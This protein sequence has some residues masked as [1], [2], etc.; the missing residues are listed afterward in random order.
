MFCG[1]SDKLFAKCVA[2]GLGIAFGDITVSKFNDGETKIVVN[3]TV[4]GKHVFVLQSTCPPNVNDNLMELLLMISTFKRAS[5]AAITAVIPYFGYARQDRKMQSRVPISAACVAQLLESMGVDRVITV[6]LHCAQIQGFFRVPTDNLEAASIAVAHFMTRGLNN[7][8]IVSPD[9]GGVGRCDVMRKLFRTEVS[10]AMII[11][12]R[13]K[14][15]EVASMDLVGNVNNVDVIIVDDMIDTA[16]TL[17]KAAQ[18]LKENGAARVFAFAT[19]P[20]FSDSAIDRINDSVLEEV[21]VTDTIKL[22]K[23]SPKIKVLT[24]APL[25]GRAIQCVIENKSV[26]AA[27]T[28]L[29]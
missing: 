18:V 17:C 8:C 16:S 26:S 10:F 22:V 3:E 4:N 7:P 23:E 5:A 25:I 15:G 20:V 13:V 28:E 1:N 6:D 11:K 14:A 24:V 9:A 29:K 12:R 27:N 19:H 21:V 2:Y